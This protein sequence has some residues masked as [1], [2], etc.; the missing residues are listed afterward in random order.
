M[1]W[2]R[3]PAALLVALFATACA[4]SLTPTPNGSGPAGAANSTACTATLSSL[5]AEAETVFGAGSPNLNSVVGKIN[6]LDHHLN[7]NNPS[8]AKVR[9]FDIVDFVLVKERESD[10][11]GTAEEIASFVNAVYCYAGVD[12]TITDPSNSWLIYPSDSAQIIIGLNGTAGISFPAFPV[13]S[14]SM[15]T[16]EQYN[17]QLNTLLDQYPGFIYIRLQSELDAALTGPATVRVCATQVPSA[18]VLADLRLG[19]GINDTGFVIAPMPAAGD[20]VNPTLSCDQPAPAQNVVARA[21]NRVAALF[22]PRAAIAQ[23]ELSFG[24]GVS[25]TVTEFSPFAPVDAE[26]SFGGGVSG[27]VTEFLRTPMS[28]ESGVSTTESCSSIPVGSEVPNECL[29]L[30]TVKTR[31]RGTPFARVPV[32]WAV[33]ATSGGTIAARAGELSYLSCGAFGRSAS[34]LTTA[35][36]NAGVCWRV[37]AAGSYGVSATVSI[38]G[39]V[40]AGVTF[41][42]NTV[43]FSLEV[44]PVTLSIVAGNGQTAPAGSTL[45][46]PPT[47]RVLTADGQPAAGV[48]VDFTALANADAIVSPTSVRTNTS[49]EA[50]TNWTIGAGYN[51]LRAMVR[52]SPDSTAVYFTANGS[53]GTVAINSCPVGGGRDPIN[54]PSRPYGFWVPGPDAG[55]TMREVDLYFGASGKANRADVY[56]I[57]LITRRGGGFLGPVVDTTI[58][59]VELRGTASENKRATFR[60]RNPIVGRTGNATSTSNAVA[61]RLVVLNQQD[62]ATINFNTGPCPLGGSCK[63]PRGCAATEVNMFTVTTQKLLGDVFRRSVGLEI[64]GN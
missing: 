15:V 11:A 37:G 27:T 8:E 20:P 36:G 9:A 49:G 31:T 14:P 35:K 34:T 26:L 45:P 47:V 43:N 10:L 61:M 1:R 24:G 44:T 38:G 59:P 51:E 63:L 50:W 54:D 30:V 32:E 55:V 28:L 42:A 46:V 22:S 19:H 3:I 21:M 58:V 64:R 29:P 48:W 16:I 52:N 33:G 39:E 4:D 12:I 60:L 23:G 6:N 41:T 2:L 18:E 25:G 62:N 40:P 7:N 13:V 56:T 53:S 17:G 57:A 5:L